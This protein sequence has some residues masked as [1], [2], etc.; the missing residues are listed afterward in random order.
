M[1][2]LDHLNANQVKESALRSQELISSDTSIF[3]SRESIRAWSFRTLPK[4]SQT[5]LIME[6]GVYGGKSLVQLAESAGRRVYGFDSFEGLRDP[7]SKPDRT[8]GAMDK[9]GQIPKLVRGREDVEIVLGWVEDTLD[10]FLREHN[11]SISIVHLDM[12]VYAPTR[13]VLERI[14]PRLSPGTHLIFDDLFGFIGWENH[15]YRALFEVFSEE[16][17]VAV[18]LSPSCAV[19]RFLGQRGTNLA[20]SSVY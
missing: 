12:D 4:G 1:D 8:S 10:P 9:K 7:W 2:W 11:E 3:S 20:K 6:F 19:F 16:E 18:A 15:S 13:F 5:G 17:L 14:K